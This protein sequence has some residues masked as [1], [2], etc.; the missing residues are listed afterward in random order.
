MNREQ[1]QALKE[2]HPEL[3][4]TKKA[5]GL[6]DEQAAAVI[7]AQIE[8][9]KANPP[10]LIAAA[11]ARSLIGLAIASISTAQAHITEAEKARAAALVL[12][13][14][15]DLPALTT[16]AVTTVETSE[17]IEPEASEP[18]KPQPP[19]KAKKK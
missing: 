2:S 14:A 6:S 10:H 16:L 11:K 8:H 9:D 4:A 5:A 13:P 7:L 3:W 19:A 1:I 12:D 18:T 17:P 15:A